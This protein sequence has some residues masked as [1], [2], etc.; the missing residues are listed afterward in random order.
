M[1]DH[2]VA[3][4]AAVPTDDPDNRWTVIVIRAASALFVGS[5]AGWVELGVLVAALHVTTPLLGGYMAKVYD[6]SLGRPRGDRLFSAIERPVYR[7]CGIKEDQE[8]RWTG[9]AGS[10]LMFSL[11]FTYLIQRIQGSLPFNP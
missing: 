1:F 11:L 7:L 8:Q 2:P 5:A 3:D 4:L 10:L 9:Y 6:P